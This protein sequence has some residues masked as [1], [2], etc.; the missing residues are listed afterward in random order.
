[1]QRNNRKQSF[2][3]T[4]HF[5]AKRTRR[6]S[7]HLEDRPSCISFT[8]ARFSSMLIRHTTFPTALPLSLPPL[9]PLNRCLS[10]IRRRIY[11]RRVGLYTMGTAL[12]EDDKPELSVDDSREKHTILLCWNV[13]WSLVALGS[14]YNSGTSRVS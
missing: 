14:K 8:L 1:M 13:D 7:T 6:P 12:E 2:T 9:W 4:R 10:K 3:V 11:V 5:I